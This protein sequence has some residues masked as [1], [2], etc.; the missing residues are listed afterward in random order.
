MED[1][2]IPI[3]WNNK[4]VIIVITFLTMILSAIVL[5]LMPNYYKASTTF[6]PVSESLQKPIVDVYDQQLSFYGNDND[7]DRLL[8]IAQSNEIKSALISKFDLMNHYEIDVEHKMSQL[9][10]R[11]KLAKLYTSQ[12]TQF[13]AVVIAIEDQD[14]QLAADIVNYARE[15]IEK[16]IIS[17]TANARNELVKSLEDESSVKRREL[18]AITTK[19]K[20]LRMKYGIYDTQSQAESLATLESKNPNGSQI[21][22]RINNYTQGVS[23]VKQLET[24]QEEL[25]KILTY[26]QNQLNKLKANQNRTSKGLH[27][28]EIA[29]KPLEKFRPK[30]SLIVLGMGLLSGFFSG[31]LLL[32]RKSLNQL[33]FSID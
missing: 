30:R 8:S 5:L 23:I 18:D 15:L 2:I 11:K 27:I 32:I 6:Y 4:K 1:N 20:D 13:D 26:D 3:L 16:K 9:K 17:M 31:L 21:K 24:Q 25:T 10:V 29:E 19:I 12:K 14:P 33:D 7:V 22:K 28:I